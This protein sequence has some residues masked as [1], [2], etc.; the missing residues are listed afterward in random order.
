MSGT[1]QANR[2]AR[3]AAKAAAAA[4]ASPA[5]SAK[6]DG[7]ALPP[8]RRLFLDLT[9]DEWSSAV[10][11][12]GLQKFRAKQVWQAVYQ[13][14]ASS[15]ND[16]QTLPKAARAELDEAFSLSLG[17]VLKH[18]VLYVS[19]PSLPPLSS[20]LFFSQMFALN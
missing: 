2:A 3:R 6:A 4:A 11:D 9:Q 10:T 8:K 1:V 15:F 16:I 7:A 20:S 5:C 14:G 19:F 12:M 17:T 18:E 13:H